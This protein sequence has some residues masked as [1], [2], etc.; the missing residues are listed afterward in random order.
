MFVH[1]KPTNDTRVQ[2][3]KG[4]TGVF[5]CAWLRF[6]EFRDDASKSMVSDSL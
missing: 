4:R 6:S 1:M 3:G 5:V 2:G